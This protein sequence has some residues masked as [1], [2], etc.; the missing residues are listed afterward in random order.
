MFADEVLRHKRAH[1]MTNEHDWQARQVGDDAL[2]QRP[3]IVYAFTPAV[4][5]GKKAKVLRCRRRPA[6]AAMVA[7]IDRI[8]SASERLC[9]PHISASMLDE[10]MDNLH[11]GLWRCFGQPAIYKE[12]NAIR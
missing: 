9:E 2:V 5:L 12:G 8:A 6:M 3:K 1:G 10:A 11:R 4:P 7:G